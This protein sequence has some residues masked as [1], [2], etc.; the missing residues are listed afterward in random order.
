MDGENGDGDGSVGEFDKARV[1]RGLTIHAVGD[2]SGMA[3]GL[4]IG[5]ALAQYTS[6]FIASPVLTRANV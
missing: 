4:S 3:L 2:G 6:R 1:R 5:Q